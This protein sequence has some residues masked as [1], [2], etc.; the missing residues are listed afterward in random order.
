MSQRP[1]TP[2]PIFFQN[3]DAPQIVSPVPSE[4][5]DFVGG[6]QH[7]ASLIWCHIQLT[8]FGPPE[9]PLQ[10]ILTAIAARSP[11]SARQTAEWTRD[12]FTRR[13]PFG[14]PEVSITY[15]PLPESCISV[16]LIEQE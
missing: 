6:I 14:C 8:M 1:P 12:Y 5:S 13:L 11:E 7:F 2:E 15:K 3:T 4:L 16:V 10:V 9:N